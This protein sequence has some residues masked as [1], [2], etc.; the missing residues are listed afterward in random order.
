MS[1]IVNRPLQ[2]YGP[3]TLWPVFARVFPP[4]LIYYEGR[5]VT[6][7]RAHNLWLDLGVS[8]GVLGLAALATLLV[9]AGH[10]LWRA[11][12]H[13]ADRWK[14]LTLVLTAAALVG[15]LAELQLSFETTTTAMTTWLMLAVAMRLAEWADI[16]CTTPPLRSESSRKHQGPA[17]SPATT[18]GAI[19][20]AAVL[21]LPALLILALIAM[22]CIR[23]LLAD[24]AFQQARQSGTSIDDRLAAAERAVRLWPLEPSYH[25]ELARIALA[26]GNPVASETAMATAT[27]LAP[28]DPGVWAAAGEVYAVWSGMSPERAV[29]AEM[30]YRQATGLAP[31]IAAYHTALGL[32]EAGQGQLEEGAAELERAVELDATDSTAYRHLSTVYETLGLSA[33]ADWARAQADYWEDRTPEG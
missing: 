7:D 8:Q 26:A 18:S 32:I 28:V 25:I 23:P 5:H 9:W 10:G 1:L 13:S 17:P 4:E 14:Q 33:K 2:G 12:R 30:A 31:N 3:E 19:S 6:I 27:A 15:H 29:Q 11:L 16:S 21:S 24:T 22:A 20:T